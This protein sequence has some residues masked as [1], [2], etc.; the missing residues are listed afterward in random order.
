M[1]HTCIPCMLAQYLNDEAIFIEGMYF[2]IF[3]RFYLK[4]GLNEV[5]FTNYGFSTHHQEAS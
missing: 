2:L 4:Q 1:A 5:N 3:H